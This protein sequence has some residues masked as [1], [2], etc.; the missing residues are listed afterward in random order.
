M[1]LVCIGFLGSRLR[2]SEKRLLEV[3]S[4]D[5]KLQLDFVKDLK[6]YG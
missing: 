4:K 6:T 2:G 3:C 1:C 5:L